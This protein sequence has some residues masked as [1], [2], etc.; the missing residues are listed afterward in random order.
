MGRLGVAAALVGDR[1]VP[2]DV[3]IE[4]G[5]VAEV[6]LEPA[7]AAGLA[8]PGFVDLQVNGFA[9]VDFLSA[10]AAGFERAGAAMAATGVTAC[11]P[12]LISAAPDAL[13]AAL[14]AAAAASPP[15]RILGV[16][17]EGPFL[18]PAWVGAHPADHLRDPDL[19]LVEELRGEGPLAAVT[20]APELPGGLDLIGALVE[21]GIGVRI[22]HTDADAS[23]AHAAF[24]R[25]ASAITHIHNAHRR[26][27]ARDPGPAGVALARRDVRVTAIV[28]GVHLAPETVV[29]VHRAAGGRLILVSDA[30]AAAG[31]GD[32]SY[33][34][35][36]SEVE[37]REGR[38]TLS[39]G[40]LAGSVGTMDGALRR[41][42]ESGATLAEAVHA[43]SREPAVLAN[44]PELGMLEPGSPADVA[45]L[46][47]RMRVTRTL[48]AGREVFAS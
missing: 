23:A 30:M 26:F 15:V 42:V 18:S 17:L 33:T 4:D 36:G 2:G 40:T 48:V 13:R 14:R 25:G 9:G 5:R 1:E 34:L 37:V 21:R 10:D 19:A 16:H 46:D 20:L 35:G 11:Q 24:D 22:G 47:D 29:L 45:V 28:D 8:V 27:A 3:T 12:T 6:G 38:S 7:G 43:A 41:L 44:R 31:L 32:G 39:D